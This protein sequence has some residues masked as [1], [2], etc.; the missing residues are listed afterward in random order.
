ME[1]EQALT[2][3]RRQDLNTPEAVIDVDIQTHQDTTEETQT[4]ERVEPQSKRT[5]WYKIRGC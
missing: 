4:E 1:K 5:A 3:E 2:P